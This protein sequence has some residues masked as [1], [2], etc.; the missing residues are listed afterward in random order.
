V[1]RL[2]KLL[3]RRQGNLGPIVLFVSR[4]RLAG[5]LL[6]GLCD[7]VAHCV[8]VWAVFVLHGIE[9]WHEVNYIGENFWT[10]HHSCSSCHQDKMSYKKTLG[11]TLSPVL[12]LLV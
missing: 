1:Q 8:A 11:V 12:E 3:L 4:L 10:L 6:V 5:H 7:D 9:V 2:L